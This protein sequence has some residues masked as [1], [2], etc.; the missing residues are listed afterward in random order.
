MDVMEIVKLV[1]GPAV[2]AAIISGVISFFATKKDRDLKYITDERKKWR[3]EIRE[4][5]V[6]LSGADYKQTIKTMT[7]LK[8]RINA[9]GI[10]DMVYAKDAHIWQ[11]I[12]CIE[13][14]S[15]EGEV[16]LSY[17]R[18]LTEYLSLLLK[19][20][21]ERAKREVKGSMLKTA[22]WICFMVASVCMGII[23]VFCGQGKIGDVK[24]LIF[25]AGVVIIF[26][27][28]LVLIY[29]YMSGEWCGYFLQNPARVNNEKY[30]KKNLLQACGCEAVACLFLYVVT[31]IV[32]A[33]VMKELGISEL[34]GCIVIIMLYSMAFVFHMIDQFTIWS[35]VYSYN[36]AIKSVRDKYRSEELK[37]KEIYDVIVKSER[38]GILEEKKMTCIV[39]KR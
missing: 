31:F 22:Q 11:V 12:A 25:L 21:W 4:I 39:E 37:E 20:D 30:G 1:V 10:D 6:E 7:K 17:Q 38:E 13:Q 23:T 2:T 15:L 14:E 24:T 34:A 27:I 36:H 26:F 9:L 16:L 19:M 5:V 3:D 8:V 18:Q 28:I 35:Q 32:V 29:F 33:G